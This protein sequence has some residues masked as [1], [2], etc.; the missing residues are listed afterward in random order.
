MSAGLS[1]LLL[2]L[3]E[4]HWAESPAKNS[5]AAV[6]S[7]LKNQVPSPFC[8]LFIVVSEAVLLTTFSRQGVFGYGLPSKAAKEVWLLWQSAFSRV[9]QWTKN[10][11][12]TSRKLRGRILLHVLKLVIYLSCPWTLSSKLIS[13]CLL[14]ISLVQWASPSPCLKI[15]SWSPPYLPSQLFLHPPAPSVPF[16]STLSPR[17]PY[18]FPL[19]SHLSSSIAI[20]SVIQATH[21]GALLDFF[22]IAH[23][24]PLTNPV[25][26]S[27]SAPYLVTC[28]VTASSSSLCP[29]TGPC[30]RLLTGR[31]HFF[32]H[33]G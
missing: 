19:L 7:W 8:D 9:C 12:L 29:L 27:K 15:M 14:G 6:E 23:L 17:L 28:L 20:C 4:E 32:H 10:L 16:P 21:L 30:Q 25:L 11:L 24:N 2:E 1:G 26:P 22:F 13:D 33:R 18:T 31:P 3:T 5:M